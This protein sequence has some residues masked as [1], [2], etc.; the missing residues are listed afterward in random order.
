MVRI[1]DNADLVPI[2]ESPI[3]REKA[4]VAR[5][6]LG[7]SWKPIKAGER[8]RQ[9]IQVRNFKLGAATGKQGDN[10]VGEVEIAK[11]LSVRYFD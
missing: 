2:E 4:V 1:E 10:D 11:G 7:R 5:R 9:R 6:I 3:L 8:F